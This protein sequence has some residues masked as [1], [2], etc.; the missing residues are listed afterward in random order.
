[1]LNRLREVLASMSKD[2]FLAQWQE[3]TER[4]KDV[5]G[6]TVKEFIASFSCPVLGQPQQFQLNMVVKEFTVAGEYNFA[7]AA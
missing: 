3:I 5:A 2:E 4:N 7:M 1:M 6:P